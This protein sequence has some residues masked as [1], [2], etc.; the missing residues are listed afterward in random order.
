MRNSS[1]TPA[2][3]FAPA[4]L[5]VSSVT[6]DA[7][8]RAKQRG[9]MRGCAKMLTAAMDTAPSDPTIIKSAEA[10]K[11]IKTHSTAAGS[12]MRKYFCS[13]AVLKSLS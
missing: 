6:A 3:S 5:A 11:L 1:E 9:T 12:A 7:M 13:S 4:F 8:D 10:R 2:T